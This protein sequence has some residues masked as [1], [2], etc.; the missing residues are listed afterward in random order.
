MLW[1]LQND[2]VFNRSAPRLATALIMAGEE[3]V[4]WGMASAKGL[5]LLTGQD[6]AAGHWTVGSPSPG[7]VEFFNL[8]GNCV[9]SI[10]CT[11]LCKLSFY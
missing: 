1:R 10:Y 6:M 7:V 5:A 9:T 3:V 4:A 8:K 2:C 11:V